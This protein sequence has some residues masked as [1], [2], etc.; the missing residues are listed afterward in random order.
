MDI[1]VT[2]D[3]RF[4]PARHCS[5]RPAA[6]AGTTYYV[7]SWLGNDSNNGLSEA[8]PFATIGK[9]NGLNLQPGDRVLFKCG[10]TW[11]A[12]QL[13]ISKSGTEA[14]PIVFGSYPEGCANKPSLSGSRP[15]AGWVFDSGNIYR[16]DL[17]VG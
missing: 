17:S 7:S 15:I 12:E 2:P 1:Y 4:K 14:A 9:V 5:P 11:R 8:K 16:A 13:V 10:D 3:Q 6:P